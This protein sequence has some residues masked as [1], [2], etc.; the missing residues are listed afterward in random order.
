[1]LYS[2]GH[3]P[4]IVIVSNEMVTLIS[5]ASVAVASPKTGIEVHSMGD[6]TAGQ[7]ITGGVLSSTT[8]DLLHVELLPQSS[9]AVHVLVTVLS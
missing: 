8:T 3:D 9:V 5:H 7:L 1:M 4:A 6:T 2:C